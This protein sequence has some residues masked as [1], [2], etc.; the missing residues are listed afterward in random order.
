MIAQKFLKT[1]Q[2]KSPDMLQGAVEYAFQRG[3]I[4]ESEYRT[5]TNRI[6]E[7]ERQKTNAL[8]EK[9]AA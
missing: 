2:V 8:L 7:V 9:F 1:L 4:S 3:D 5:W 6:I